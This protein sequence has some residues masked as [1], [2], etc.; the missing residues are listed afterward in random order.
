VRTGA[1]VAEPVPAY[2]A[3]MST[4]APE[5]LPKTAPM[6]APM[7]VDPKMGPQSLQRLFTMLVGLFAALS[8]AGSVLLWAHYG[9]TVFFE[10]IRA[11]FSACFG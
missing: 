5:V 7:T 1:V 6:T 2:L 3:V 11:G 4:G 10:T 9:T 8:V